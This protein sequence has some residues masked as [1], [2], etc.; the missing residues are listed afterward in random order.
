MRIVLG[1]RLIG[2]ALSYLKTM[3][4]VRNSDVQEVQR[5]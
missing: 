3:E 2:Y 5:I 1:A 4:A